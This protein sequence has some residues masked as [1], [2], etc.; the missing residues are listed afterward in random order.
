[1]TKRDWG[2]VKES[3]TTDCFVE[4]QGIAYI[5]C[6]KHFGRFL[7]LRYVIIGYIFLDDPTP[8]MLLKVNKA[9]P[10]TPRIFIDAPCKHCE[11]L[12]RIVA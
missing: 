3:E 8:D 9:F 7:Y 5:F 6:P 12:R 10:K 2:K 1:M 11:K 4:T